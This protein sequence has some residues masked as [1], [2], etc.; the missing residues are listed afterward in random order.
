MRRTLTFAAM[1]ALCVAAVH[2]APVPASSTVT[3]ITGDKVTFSAGKPASV[4]VQPR[5]G[6]EN[7]QFV[8][9]QESAGN[10]G[11][12]HFYVIPADAVPLIA[13]GGLDRQLFDVTELLNSH[14]DDVS[15]DTLPLIV[16]YHAQLGALSTS[17]TTL[18]GAT[19]TQ[20]LYT[21]NGLAVNAHKEEINTLWN[22]LTTTMAVNA[23]ATASS[24]PIKKVWLDRLIRPVLDQSAPQIGA[25]TAW[26]QG[27]EGNGVRVAVVDTGI[28]TTHP[29]LAGKVIAERNFTTEP[30]TDEVG[31][32]THVASIIAGS[33]AA[34]AGQYRGVAPGVEL[35]SAKACEVFGCGLSAIIAGVQ[36][37]VTEEGAKIVNLSLGGT[38]T[39]D[40]DP[41]EQTINELTESHG[42]L[43]VVAAGNSFA[44]FTVSSPATADAALAVAAV[45]RTDATAPFSSRGPRISDKG[46]K[47]EISAPGVAIIAA[48]AV[49]TSPPGG[50]PV[51]DSYM[52]LSGTSMATPHV[53][54]AAA[55]LAQLHPDFSPAQL[56]SVLMGSAKPSASASNFNPVFEQGAGRVDVAA[57][58]ST[59]LSAEPASLSLGTAVWPHGD[60]P[61]ITRVVTYRNSGTSAITLNLKV[62]AATL[63]NV[64]AGAGLFSLDHD[65][66][67]VPAGGD[68]TVTFTADTRVV[69]ADSIYGG[70]IIATGPGERISTPFSIEREPESYDVLVRHIDRRG[71]LTS[72]Y[73]M[74]FVPLDQ[75]LVITPRLTFGP[76]EATIRVPAGRYAI[77][78]NLLGL[79]SVLMVRPLQV[80]N[81]PT[82]VT[83][84][85]REASLLTLT[86]PTAT[87]QRFWTQL[88]VEYPATWGRARNELL[89][90]GPFQIYTAT[91]GDPLPGLVSF[92]TAQWNDGSADTAALYAGAWVQKDHVVTGPTLEINPDKQSV[93][94]SQYA[95]AFPTIS[96][97]SAAIAPNI[98]DSSVVFLP[99][100]AIPLPSRR[101]EYLFS[102]GA[103]VPWI[104]RLNLTASDVAQFSTGQTLYKPQRLYFLRWNEPPFG[105]AFPANFDA[106]VRSGDVMV[107]Q[108][109]LFGDRGGHA[110]FVGSNA[111]ITVFRE[112]Q[113]LVEADDF[114]VS[115]EVPPEEAKYRVE[116]SATQSVF[117]LST[118][119]S[120][121]Y[122]FESGQVDPATQESLP[123][124]SVSFEPRLNELGQAPRDVLFE[125]PV[126]VRQNGKHGAVPVSRLSVEASFDDGA[127]W[128]RVPL[129]PQGKDGKAWVALLKHPR[130]GEFVSLRAVARDLRSSAVEQTTIRAYALT[131]KSKDAP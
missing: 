57:A 112:G 82:T 88:G 69:A 4:S 54:G 63:D 45:D 72:T 31:H 78:S 60:D 120:A 79:D 50:I 13:A 95:S 127:T 41:L 125:V 37:A 113:K 2:A 65:T 52:T 62:E 7:I 87:A 38:D 124:L 130:Q 91:L 25:P 101:T 74:T 98:N 99:G 103:E 116:A 39:P 42:T 131:E 76:P 73:A 19:R 86:P 109:P 43:F 10:Q 24:G 108:A 16:T 48:R 107:V 5:K 104:N 71:F 27:Y 15:R 14:Y 66:V 35:I 122:T 20:E 123:L 61:V 70:R 51:G 93:L 96:Q 18:A 85:A 83:F 90:S 55:L 81:A 128:Q 129:R 46:V 119:V 97:G 84:D 110:G 92:L 29:D 40:I 11:E 17:S 8:T 44:P 33:G 126:S 3:L 12:L 47:P 34:S 49:G 75:R 56:K 32:G 58:F 30:G 67:V 6:R 111:H 23:R 22:S 26:A 21:V 28:D 100:V 106:A 77:Q 36:W 117:G 9:H 118:R 121:A 64:A 80:I 68:A 94:R 102:T 1:M 105:P 89:L 114:G 53:A 115:L 59:H